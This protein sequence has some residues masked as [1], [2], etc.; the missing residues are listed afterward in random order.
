[1]QS[2]QAAREAVPAGCLVWME[3]YFSMQPI[4]H[5][6]ILQIVDW[7]F[8]TALLL[9]FSL[10]LDA[11]GV[12]RVGTDSDQYLEFADAILDGSL[13]SVAVPSEVS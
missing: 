13:F 11:P 10:H 5:R 3:T 8:L 7:R 2:E 1:M 6:W 4:R 12:A 9:F